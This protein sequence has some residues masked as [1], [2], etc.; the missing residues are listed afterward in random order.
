MNYFFEGMCIPTFEQWREVIVRSLK[1]QLVTI[2][3]NILFRIIDIR[4]VA[5]F[6]KN[7]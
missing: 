6:Y 4:C 5:N 2:T 7:D 3:I 1:L